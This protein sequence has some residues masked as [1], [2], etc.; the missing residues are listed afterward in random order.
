MPNRHSK[1]Q[2]EISL[3]PVEAEASRPN[4]AL[5]F[6]E[7]AS[8][9]LKASEIKPLRVKKPKVDSTHLATGTFKGQDELVKKQEA[10]V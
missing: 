2:I 6:R 7:S 1:K 9:E 5:R 10:H 4:S 8:S 3:K